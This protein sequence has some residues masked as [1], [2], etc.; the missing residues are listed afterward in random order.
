MIVDDETGVRTLLRAVLERHGYSVITAAD[1]A[2][3]IDIFEREGDNIDLVILDLSMPIMSGE[4]TFRELHRI[5]PNTP[6]LLSSGF[7]ESE[8]V[9]RFLGKGL[10]GFVQ[11]PYTAH[12]ITESI[13]Q[14]LSRAPG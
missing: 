2:Q 12:Q 9:R 11:K 13:R 4:E 5:R 8:A 3:A 14:T 1:G 7:N 6:V 10:A